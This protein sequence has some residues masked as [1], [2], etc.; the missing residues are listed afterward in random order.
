MSVQARLLHSSRVMLTLTLCALVMTSTPMADGEPFTTRIRLQ[1]ELE[2]A[3]EARPRGGWY[4]L[5]TPPI[6]VGVVLGLVGMTT[7]FYT[8]PCSGFLCFNVLPDGYREPSSQGWVFIGAGVGIAMVGIA[9]TVA[10]TVIRHAMGERIDELEQA[11]EA[12]QF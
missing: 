6:G 1:E 12:L 2:A 3:R 9:A 4:A 8:N 10:F 7:G 11:L 5:T